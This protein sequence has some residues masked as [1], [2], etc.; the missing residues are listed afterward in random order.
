MWTT[1]ACKL[2]CLGGALALAACSGGGDSL[3]RGHTIGGSVAG[4][5]GSG[6]VLATGGQANLPVS[7]GQAA[8]TF[9]SA[10]PAGTAYEVTV[11]TQPS[12][13]RQT[14]LVVGGKGTVGD[15]N[16]TGI[17]V[18]CTAAPDDYTSITTGP[19]AVIQ[20]I[21]GHGRYCSGTA[22]VAARVPAAPVYVLTAGHC[23]AITFADEV[24]ADVAN[25]AGI[26]AHFNGFVDAPPEQ[27]F[28]VPVSTVRYSTMWG[29]DLSLLE[30]AATQAEL[31]ALG[32]ELPTLAAQPPTSGVVFTYG[33]RD[34]DPLMRR[35]DCVLG[36][37]TW[38]KE[39]VWSWWAPFR[40]ECPTT[41]IRAGASGSPVFAVDTSEFFGVV[42]T[43]SEELLA[44]L[45]ELN[46]PCELRP[47]GAENVP[48]RAYFQDATRLHGCFTADGLFDRALSECGLPGSTFGLQAAGQAN[49]L[50]VTANTA[51]VAAGAYRWKVTPLATFDPVDAAGYSAP[52]TSP[53]ILFTPPAARY[54]VSAV[55]DTEYAPAGLDPLAVHAVIRWQ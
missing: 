46:Y 28:S 42:N 40:G 53:T 14:C 37:R 52:S 8:F 10:V 49:Q 34:D 36:P 55:S 16:V 48:L 15:A 39:T 17:T 38:L 27:R 47:V 24:F 6:L 30:L 11:A 43:V 4:L 35:T 12:T 50:A 20:L 54:V 13:P 25:D 19:R 21:D 2:A 23:Y 44:P 45:C 9:A 1:R 33:Y 7:A 31:S 26:A 51:G 5:S 18:I 32:V 29:Q 22:F 41:Y 3:P